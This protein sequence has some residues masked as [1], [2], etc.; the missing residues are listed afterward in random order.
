MNLTERNIEELL[1]AIIEGDE[2]AFLDLDL[3][4]TKILFRLLQQ[5]YMSARNEIKEFR[6]A[7]EHLAE[8][9]NKFVDLYEF[10]PI[11]YFILNPEAEIVELNFRA[12]D[13]LQLARSNFIPMALHQ[14]VADASL[15]VF[16]KLLGLLAETS[17]MQTC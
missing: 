11:G 4:E 13:M 5:E 17:D 1:N 6:A 8:I 3:T 2:Q 16:H 14:F 12:A 15:E 7:Q 9:R 10:A